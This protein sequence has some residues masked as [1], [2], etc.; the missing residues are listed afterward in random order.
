VFVRAEIIRPGEALADTHDDLER[1]SERSRAA[2]E[3]HE[4]EFQGYQS[5]PGI[6]PKP[7]DPEK[8]LDAH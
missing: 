5:W 7:T 6:K 3:K 1:I 2:F 4:D 8:V